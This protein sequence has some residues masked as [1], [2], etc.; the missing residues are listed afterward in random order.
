MAEVTD[1]RVVVLTHGRF[2]DRAKTALGVMRYGRFDVVAV[3]DSELAG[4]RVHDHVS[5]VPDAPI[6]GNLEEIDDA[7]ALLIGVA[8]IGGGFEETWRDDVRTALSRGW[9]LIAGLHTFL[10]DDDEFKQLATDNDASIWDVRRPPPG[11]SVADGIA[12]SVEARVILTVGTDCSVGKMTTTFELAQECASHGY[13]AAVIPTGQTG[14]MIEQWGYPV[15]RVISDFV[16]G[17]VE[18]LVLERGDDHDILIVE[19]Q[20]SIVHPAY[21]AVTCG[22]LHGAMPDALVL[23]HEAGRDRVN[24]Y[25]SFDL[26]PVERIAQLYETIAEPVAA[27]PVV[28]GSLNT[29]TIEHNEEAMDAVAAM[30]QR[31]DIPC[32]DVVRFEPTP[33]LE[34][35]V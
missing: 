11:L 13:D 31:L 21:S 8:P 14:I 3:L 33:V 19:G 25:E 22:I 4:T 35:I 12:D 27:A 20:G 26:F 30:E 7:D 9:K 17:A 24:G 32:A 1:R 28:A 10:E 29:R 15:D 23:C 34:A 18:D 5:S 6:V 2:P 16:A